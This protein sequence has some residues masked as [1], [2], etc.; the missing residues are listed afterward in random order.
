MAGAAPV[1]ADSYTITFAEAFNGNSSMDGKSFKGYNVLKTDA[2]NNGHLFVLV[3][4][5]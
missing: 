4:M 2:N 1:A 3:S 5:N